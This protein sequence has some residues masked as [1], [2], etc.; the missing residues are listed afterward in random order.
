MTFDRHSFKV[1]GKI[2][3]PDSMSNTGEG[4]IIESAGAGITVQYDNKLGKQICFYSFDWL[5][6]QYGD[7]TVQTS[8]DDPPWDDPIPF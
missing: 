4:E 7:R 6:Q 3:V 2:I 8:S 5:N 1:G